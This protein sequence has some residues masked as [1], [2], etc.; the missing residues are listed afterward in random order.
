MNSSQQLSEMAMVNLC[1][2]IQTYKLALCNLTVPTPSYHA[3]SK[4][5][6]DINKK[7]AL[8]DLT[9]A[10]PNWHARSNFQFDINQK[11]LCYGILPC[12]FQIIIPLYF[13]M[14]PKNYH[15]HSKLPCALKII[16]WYN[17]KK[18]C[19]QWSYRDHSKL[20]SA[21]IYNLI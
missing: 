10:T 19:S 16:M 21:P 2:V 4:L 15:A 20:P 6:C 9:M 17:P 11:Y 14:P 13:T 1:H 5:P 3:R 18:K 7:N 8:S 12:S